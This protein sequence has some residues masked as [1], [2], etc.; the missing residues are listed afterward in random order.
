MDSGHYTVIAGGSGAAKFLRGL[1]QVVP[2]DRIHV[3]VNVGDDTN[4]WGL[5]ISPDIDSIVYG[6][7]GKLDPVRGWGL[8]DETFRCL[9]TMTV[10][11][12]PA[13][14]R[15]GDADLATHLART[16]LL[17]SGMSLTAV[18]A[19]MATA[20]GVR[21]RILPATN[22]SVR[23]MVETPHGTLGFQEFFVREQCKPEVKSVSYS[24]A[25]EA[26][27]PEAVLQSIREAQ[28][29]IIAP[30]N[31]ITSIGPI[32]ALHEIR[33]ALRCTRSEIVAIS[34][35]VGNAAVSGP[36][37]KLMQASGYDVSPEGVARCYHDFLDNIVI[38]T[39]DKG[40][41]STIRYET[42]GVQVTDILMRDDAAARSLAQFVIDENSSTPR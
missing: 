36:A 29:I 23:T 21:A 38:H 13:W 22:D 12:M 19:R 26:R 33:E 16:E 5:H 18:V 31:P 20:L 28:L 37:G 32:L 6:L 17:R 10:Y 25:L 42:I 41:A 11:D 40:L 39:S 14:F 8:S 15:L 34:P 2:E 4:I 7:S 27:A 9:E 35:I 24:G 30:S 1:I 3:I